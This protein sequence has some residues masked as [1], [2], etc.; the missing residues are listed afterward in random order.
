MATQTGQKTDAIEMLKTDHRKVLDLFRQFSEAGERAHK[1][2][3]KL[4]DQIFQELEVHSK[5]EEEIFY[6]AVRAVADQEQEELVDEGLEE[7]HVVDL[8]IQELRGMTPE[9]DNYD[10]K[11]TVLCENV[12]HHIQEEEGEMLPDARKKLGDQTEQLAQEMSVLKKQLI[13]SA[14]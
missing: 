9:D 3:Q 1:T 11:M 10:A 5:L 8:L 13:G 14:A 12:E 2:K 6:P 4:A 7:H